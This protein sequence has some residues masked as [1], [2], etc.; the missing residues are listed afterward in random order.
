MLCRNVQFCPL[1]LK[2]FINNAEESKYLL[3]NPLN[4]P[5]KIIL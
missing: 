2:R 3:N 5:L 1:K 4:N